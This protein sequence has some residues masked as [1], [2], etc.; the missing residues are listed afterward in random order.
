[1]V[2]RS[3]SLG[4][5]MRYR[6]VL[7]AAIV[8]GAR[9]PAI[10]LLH[11]GGGTFRDWTNYS[12]VARIAASE[13]ILI[14]PQGDYSYYVNAVGRPADRYEDYILRDLV[15]DAESRFPIAAGREN[16]AIA[17]VS[18]GG[19]GAITIA[20]RH[21][22]KFVFA[23][24]LSPAVDVV[25]RPFSVKRIQQ[26]RAFATLFGPWNSGARSALDPFNAAKFVSTTESPY[27]FLTCGDQESLLLPNRAFAALLARQH[28]P[29]EFHVVQ[30]GH[31]W[32]QWNQQVPAM[33]VQIRQH[34]GPLGK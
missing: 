31:D 15:A 29:Y 9:L 8:P 10:Y 28:L 25:R 6:V 34:I 21:P 14:M 26:S 24:A 19:F 11:G 12:G 22:D 5:E 3:A 17:G 4:R 27:L 7:P 1:M 20:L 32:N 33:F 23:G 18:M 2:F 16:R 30:G 13:F